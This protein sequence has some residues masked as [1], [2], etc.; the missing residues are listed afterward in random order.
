M[1]DDYL[2]RLKDRWL[3]PLAQALGRGVTP[4]SVTLAALIAGVATA[5][6]IAAGATTLALAL[7]ILN[8]LLDGLDGTLAR[9][10]GTQSDLGGYVDIVLDFV[11]YAII[12]L[13][14]VVEAG[15][16]RLAVL[17]G[18][19]LAV[20]FVN[21]ASW[22]YL[23]AILERRERGAAATG[24]LTTVTMPPGIVAGAETFVLYA[25]LIALPEWRA[26]GFLVMGAL[27]S[28]NVLQRFWWAWR[29]LR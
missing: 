22:M 1:F 25:G 26:V 9:V 13:A 29:E 24:E 6:A 19:L 28:V 18:G 7:W 5:W 20:F 15:D 23:A 8:R 4:M 12:P 10:Q 2:R 21:A 11:V 16:L 14:M 27:V 3:T 17:G